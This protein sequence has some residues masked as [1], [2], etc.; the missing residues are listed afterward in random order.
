M[1][2][3]QSGSGMCSPPKFTDYTLTILLTVEFLAAPTTSHAS[4]VFFVV[5]L[6]VHWNILID[7]NH[8]FTTD[9]VRG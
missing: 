4:K 3:Q 8:T 9:V 7:G 2:L 5:F 1:L 6:S